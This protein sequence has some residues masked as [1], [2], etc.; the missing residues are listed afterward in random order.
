M[1]VY[2][3]RANCRHT[4]WFVW[5]RSRLTII[6]EGGLAILGTYVVAEA[7]NRHIGTVVMRRRALKVSTIFMY[8]SLER[9]AGDCC[10]CRHG[11]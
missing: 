9:P 5:A 10:Q 8:I 7:R 2:I 4:L 3:C 11:Q 6:C 1:Q